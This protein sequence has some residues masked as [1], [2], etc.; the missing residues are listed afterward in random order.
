MKL[1]RAR[2]PAKEEEALRPVH[3]P[4]SVGSESRSE[5]RTVTVLTFNK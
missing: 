5:T 4:L 3:P 2:V 1:R